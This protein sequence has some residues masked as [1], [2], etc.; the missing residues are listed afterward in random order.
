MSETSDE[1]TEILRNLTVLVCQAAVLV[2]QKKEPDVTPD[3][4][5]RTSGSAGG[6]LDP[7]VPVTSRKVYYTAVKI[8]TDPVD[9]V[10]GV[11]CGGHSGTPI[12][13]YPIGPAGVDVSF[14]LRGDEWDTGMYRIWAERVD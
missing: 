2:R 11:L 1:L 4:F 3:G 13:M 7:G 10:P 6:P 14:T 5:G 8:G 12:G 9:Y